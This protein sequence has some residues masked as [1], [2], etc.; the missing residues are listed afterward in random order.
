[1]RKYLKLMRVHHYIKN[2]LIFTPTIFSGYLFEKEIFWSSILGFITFSFLAS[3]IYI[4]NDIQDVELDRLHPTKRNRPLAANVITIKRAKMIS[5]ILLV[6]MALTNIYISNN[7]MTW[8]CLLAYLI[9]NIAYSN[10]LKNYPIIDVTILVSGFVI[11]VI[12]GSAVTGI[13]ISKWLYLTVIALSFYLG[14]GKRRNELIKQK[15]TSRK[16][17]QYYNHD[18]LDKNMY[19]C[20]ALTIAFYSLWTVDPLTI[21]RI[22]NNYLI[23]T[24]LLVI[25]ICMKYSL[26]IETTSDGDP[27]EVILSDKLL[28]L[29][30]ILF[31]VITLAIIYI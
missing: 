23:W 30:I 13:E 20:L 26:N 12:Y 28:L 2:L 11:R 31:S 29:L 15:A 4:I 25:I 22:S 10:G 6:L 5:V 1:M 7:V 17:L 27:V 16:V 21:E 19:M 18:F 24:V 8:I 14:L 3:F 9:L